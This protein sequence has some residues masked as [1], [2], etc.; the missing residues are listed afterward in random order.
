MVG[1]AG[2]KFGRYPLKHPGREYVKVICDICHGEFYQKDTTLVTDKYNLQYGKLVCFA[3]LDEINE[4]VLPNYHT[5]QPTPNP[6]LLRPERAFRF[7]VNE[8]DDRLPSAPLH[9]LARANSVTNTIDLLWQGPDDNGS[10]AIIGYKIVRAFPQLSDYSTLVSDTGTG[11]PYYNDITSEF[12]VPSSYKVA[13]LNSFG[14]GA[15]SVD[16]YW[17]VNTL[18][19][20]DIEYLVISPGTDVLE[21][22]GFPLRMNHTAA[23][24][25]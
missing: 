21:I 13:A 23:G 11:S 19:W 10:S 15:Y 7:A 6:E 17:P 5:D 18:N 25:A 14:T 9:P 22:D 2:A 8:N 12:T 3:D 20:S 4:Q 1:K 16:F 24:L